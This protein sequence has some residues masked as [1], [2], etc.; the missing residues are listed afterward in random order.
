VIVNSPGFIQH[1][2]QLGARQVSLIPNGA[3]PGMFDPALT[4]AEFRQRYGLEG[5]FI[6]LYAG[7]HGLSNDLQV[8]LEAAR[9][10][11]ADETIRFVFVG[12]GKEK[13]ALQ[14]QAQAMD[15][16]NVVFI[17][18]VPKT[19]MNQALAAADA[20]IAILKPL[21][22]YKTTYPNKVF[23]YMA[24]GRPV[25]LAIDGV[26]RQV[27]EG[28]QAGLYVPPG[29]ASALAQA[30]RCLSDDP[31]TARQMGQAGRN[32]IENQFNRNLQTQK[33]SFLLEEMG[34]TNA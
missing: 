21:D 32:C 18:P 29:N 28:A 1:V 6:A 26:I 14:A 11:A 34:K 20:C 22:W 13:Q 10:L 19:E 15:L 4:G 23:D 24:A 16:P 27:V 2:S 9:Q 30:V 7:A 12:D 33:F 17:P 3:E 5:K 25:I 8:V 31:Q